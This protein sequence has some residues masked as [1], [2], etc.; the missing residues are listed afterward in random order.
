MTQ[1]TTHALFNATH[2]AETRML[3]PVQQHINHHFKTPI[4]ITHSSLHQS[5]YIKRMSVMTAMFHILPPS[6]GVSN[7]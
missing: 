5:A 6:D 2:A 4:G 1:R 3:L 7:Y